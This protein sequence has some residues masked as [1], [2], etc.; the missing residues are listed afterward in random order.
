MFGAKMQIQT[1]KIF[2][3]LADTESFS[4]AAAL[5][6]ITQSAV[7][8]QIRA[9]EERY[10]AMLIERG[11]KNF[12]LTQEGRVFLEASKSIL[13]IFEGVGEQIKEMQNIVAGE[14]RVATVYSIGLHELP[15][16]LKALP[17][18]DASVHGRA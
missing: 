14:L 6:D 18:L 9:L 7:S 13:E 12:S 5:N 10:Q 8:Q 1:F 3:D 16:F 11:K 17:P 2:C 15:P 4:R